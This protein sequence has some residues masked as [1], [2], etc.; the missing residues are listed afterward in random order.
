MSSERA[1]VDTR[2]YWFFKLGWY[3]EPEGNNYLENDIVFR[4]ADV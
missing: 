4:I 2:S 3:D 1:E